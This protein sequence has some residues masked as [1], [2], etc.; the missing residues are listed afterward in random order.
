MSI[1]QIPDIKDTN[2]NLLSYA[3]IIL[4]TLIIFQSDAQAQVISSAEI[5]SQIASQ[6][7]SIYTKNTNAD[8]EKVLQLF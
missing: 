7:E 6:L 1:K 3:L 8:V 2:I 5:K 4:L